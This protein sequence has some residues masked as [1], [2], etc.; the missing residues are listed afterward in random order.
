MYITE[1]IAQLANA[2]GNILYAPH[3]DAILTNPVKNSYK[4]VSQQV[5]D[6]VVAAG[7]LS[8][9]G[10]GKIVDTTVLGMLQ[11]KQFTEEQAI[12][13][14]TKLVGAYDQVEKLVDYDQKSFEE[15][16]DKN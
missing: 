7:S 3:D 4:A 12:N 1:K 16:I 5:A 6:K 13:V 9:E 14:T 8:K 15:S 11:S 10:Y 2:I